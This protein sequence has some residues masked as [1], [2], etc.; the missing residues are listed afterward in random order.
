MRTVA[1][2]SAVRDSVA[3]RTEELSSWRANM[4]RREVNGK[5]QKA[6][7]LA[8]WAKL[9]DLLQPYWK[10]AEASPPGEVLSRQVGDAPH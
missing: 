9:N 2:P 3:T 6:L 7:V 10:E 1:K 5:M 4:V 8:V